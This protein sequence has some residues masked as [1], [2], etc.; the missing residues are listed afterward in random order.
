VNTVISWVLAYPLYAFG[1]L[2]GLALGIFYGFD[3]W[4]GNTAEIEQL[5]DSPRVKNLIWILGAGVT[6]FFR[7]HKGAGSA[8]KSRFAPCS[9]FLSMYRG[10]HCSRCRMGRRDR[11][12]AG[13]REFPGTR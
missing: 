3:G 13:F 1:M 2:V 10:R 8:G 7:R 11:N 5:Q 6:A 4:R 9:V 12:W